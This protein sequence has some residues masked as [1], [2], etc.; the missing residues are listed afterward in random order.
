MFKYTMYILHVIYA[1]TYNILIIYV[2]IY[3]VHYTS[4]MPCIYIHSNLSQ[5][6]LINTGGHVEFLLIINF[7]AN[8]D[9]G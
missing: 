5:S 6:E 3:V 9:S 1:C 7:I 2:C 8:T 4:Y